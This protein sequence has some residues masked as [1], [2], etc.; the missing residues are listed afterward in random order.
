MGSI[1][2]LRSRN[3]A[4][5]DAQSEFDAAT[6]ETITRY[7]AVIID[8]DFVGPS[9]AAAGGIPTA[10]T[11]GYPWI[12]KTVKT[13]GTPTVAAL[14]NA[15]GGIVRCA[16]D[17]TSEKQEATLYAADVLN[18]DMTKS[19]IL[20]ARISNHVVPSAAAVEMVF[21]LHSA[22]IDGPDNASFY[23]D[24]Q[25]LASGA[26]NMRTKDGVQT[27]SKSTGVVMTVDAFHIFRIDAMDPTNVRF[28]IDGAEVSTSGQLSFAAT[29]ANA[30]LQP[31]FTVYKASGVGVGTFDLDMV[32]V[33][34]N[35]S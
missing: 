34:M 35:R 4:T 17:A 18:W 16:L 25:Q 23:A 9:H 24:F 3:A 10:A 12:Q 8:E 32:Q 20:E 15:G 11:V 19:A 13:G 6:N 26:V 29:G 28:F 27:L 31:Y 5:G 2:S 33:G 30:V 1:L 21:G 7:T 14:A 22:W